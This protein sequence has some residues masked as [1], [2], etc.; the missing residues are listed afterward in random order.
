MYNLT[1]AMI[2]KNE[3]SN[4]EDCLKS[5]SSF[6]NYYVIA[7]TG[8]TDNTKEIIKKFFDDKGIPGEVLDHPW[9]DFGT[10]RSKVLAHCYGKTKWA[11]MIDADDYI[12]GDLPVN[13]FDNTLDGYLVKLGRGGNIW[14]RSQIFNLAKKKWWYEEPLHE[15]A[16]C[17]QPMNL[18]KLEGNYSW[19]ARTQG[20]RSKSVS[21]DREKYARDYFTLK[22]HLETDPTSVRKQFYA[23][24]SAFDCELYEIA[25]KEYIKRTEMGGWIEEIYYSWLRIGICRERL[26]KPVQDI[27]DAYLKAYEIRPTRSESLYNL[28]CLYRKVDRPKNAFLVASQGLNLPLPGEDALF[29]DSSV[30]D[31]GILDEISATAYYVGKYQLGYDVSEKL[32]KSSNIPEFH[33]ERIE[34]NKKIYMAELDKLNS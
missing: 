30:Y 33:R 18:K 27:A 2:V 4:I 14:Y 29:I 31:W 34:S 12:E 28:S 9:E 22:K 32:L 17:E 5:V 13:S 1:L 7:D 23:A 20:C 19:I 8:S 26:Q 6:I 16:C 10:N 15:Y 25:E 24:Q 11:I 21:S 3:S